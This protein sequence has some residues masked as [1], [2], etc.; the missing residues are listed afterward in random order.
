M[1]G[2]SVR[3]AVTG[4]S[5]F[6]GQ[7]VLAALDRKGI[8]YLSIGRTRPPGVALDRYRAVDLLSDDLHASFANLECTHLIHLAW[9]TEH[10]RYWTSAAN[11]DWAMAS[12]SLIRAFCERGV[13]VTA[14]GTCAEYDWSAGVCIE[15]KTPIEP[16]TLYGKAKA[17]T[18]QLVMAAC[19]AESIPCCWARLFIPF[20]QGESPRRLIPS[21]V[22]AVLGRSPP[23]TIGGENWRDFLAVEDVADALV[24]LAVS[25]YSGVVNICSGIPRQ[26]RGLVDEIAGYLGRSGEAVLDA[27]PGAGDARW[28]IGDD[29]R[30]RSTGWSPVVPFSDR[31]AAYV[32]A[33]LVTIE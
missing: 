13:H 33:R 8:P 11:L 16:A 7:H 1:V 31:L 30:L 3:V 10:G 19:S 32:N 23:I 27:P 29:S 21:I 6:V 12:L 17:A 14:I 25:D 15:G 24:H 22:D 28:V 4:G 18:S 9:Y 20:G 5:G 2:R 26:I